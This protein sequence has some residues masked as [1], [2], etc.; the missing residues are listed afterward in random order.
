LQF[1]G[2]LEENATKLS[3]EDLER[4]KKQQAIVAEVVTI[5]EKP[6]YSDENTTASTEI[7]RLMSEVNIF[8]LLSSPLSD[9]LQ[10]A[11]I[12]VAAV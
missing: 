11:N 8:A 7:V 9:K 6:G 1:P 4:Y 3:S 12:W 2:Y 10:D 5:F